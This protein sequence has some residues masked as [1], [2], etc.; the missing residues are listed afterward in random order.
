MPIHILL[1]TLLKHSGNLKFEVMAQPPYSPDLAPSERTTTCS[2][3][4]EALRGHQS[5][6]D[7]EVKDAVHTWLAVQLKSFSEGIREVVQ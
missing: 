6:P 3:H 4:S 1:S 7:Q 2:V 5:T